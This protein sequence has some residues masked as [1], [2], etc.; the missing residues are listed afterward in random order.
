MAAQVFNPSTL[1]ER[2]RKVDPCE[3]KASLVYTVSSGPAKAT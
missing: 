3:Y 1:P 2:Q